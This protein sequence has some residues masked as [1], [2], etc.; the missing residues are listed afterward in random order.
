MALKPR[1]W[2]RRVQSHCY[3]F[4]LFLIIVLIAVVLLAALY[5]IGQQVC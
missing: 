2:A 3:R 4:S 5:D 1:T